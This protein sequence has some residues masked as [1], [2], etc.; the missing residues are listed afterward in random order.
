MPAPWKFRPGE[1]DL[2]WEDNA[3]SNTMAW[4]SQKVTPSWCADED[5]WTVRWTMYLWAECPCC[6]SIR[7]LIVGLALGLGLGAIIF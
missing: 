1:D 2:D 7:W 3:V 6:L 4:V 5:H